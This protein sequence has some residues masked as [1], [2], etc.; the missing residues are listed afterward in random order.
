MNERTIFKRRIQQLSKKIASD[1]GFT[2]YKRTFLIKEESDI[3]CM[4]VFDF[5]PTA[6]QV[7]VAVQPL[8]IP[9]E[10]LH[11]TVGYHIQRPGLAQKGYWGSDPEYYDCDINEI[12]ETIRNEA[13][14]FFQTVSTPLKLIDCLQNDS[15]KR[16]RVA[17]VVSKLHVAY[18]LLMTRQYDAALPCFNAVRNDLSQ[19]TIESANKQLAATEKII[20]MI[21]KKDYDGI[22]VF[23]QQ[24]ITDVKTVCGLI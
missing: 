20:S 16:I 3:V 10:R 6:M 1:Y 19:Y 5:P 4:I 13:L 11:I 24:T 2:L 12:A 9:S 8:Y 23:L 7:H 22:S 14:P 18:S 15:S 21:E 17:P